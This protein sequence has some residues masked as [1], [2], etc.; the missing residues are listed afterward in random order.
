MKKLSPNLIGFLFALVASIV[1]MI[2]YFQF[3]EKERYFLMDNPT[4]STIYVT[5]DGKEY[6][7]SPRQ[8]I[9][10]NLKRG[11]HSMEV[12]SEVDSLNF[13]KTDFVIHN[14]QGLLN[15]TRSVYFTFAMPYGPMVDK[16][17]I[18]GELKVNFEGKTYYGD[19]QIDSSVYNENFYYNLDEH[20]PKI[21][22]RSQNKELR[23]KIFRV[24]DFKQ[25]YFENYE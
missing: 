19:I 13:P 8:Q 18:F 22:K 15:P 1:I 16:D 5:L 23:I 17:S 6:V 24:G 9:K 10:L 4:E 12:I 21:T 20:F 2:V 14:V 3:I 11:E 25:F 7:V